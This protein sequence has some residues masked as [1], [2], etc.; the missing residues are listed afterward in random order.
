M[1]G[2]RDHERAEPDAAPYRCQAGKGPRRVVVLRSSGDA[3]EQQVGLRVRAGDERGGAAEDL[4]RAVGGIGVHE[5][6]VALHL[7]PYVAGQG[8]SP[9]NSKSRPPT[10]TASR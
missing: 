8:P 6:A 4:G 9:T 1:S 2:W 7:M 5:H 10:V 3:G